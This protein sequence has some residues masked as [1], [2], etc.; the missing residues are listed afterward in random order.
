[1][2]FLSICLFRNQNKP[3]LN[4][5]K[6]G[7]KFDVLEKGVHKVTE[8]FF[9]D[10]LQCLSNLYNP[11]KVGR[12]VSRKL[13]M[14]LLVGLLAASQAEFNVPDGPIY[15]LNEADCTDG[16]GTNHCIQCINCFY[17]NYDGTAQ[18]GSVCFEGAGEA[19]PYFNE[20]C[21]NPTDESNSVYDG[22]NGDFLDLECGPNHVKVRTMCT[23]RVEVRTDN[24]HVDYRL[25]R[26][27]RAIR[28]DIVDNGLLGLPS[29]GG[30]YNL[31]ELRRAKAHCVGDNCNDLD[32]TPLEQT[33]ARDT[34]LQCKSCTYSKDLDGN[35]VDEDCVSNPTT[36]VTCD[37]SPGCM[38]DA[39]KECISF[40]GDNQNCYGNT[41][42]LRRGCSDYDEDTE[43]ST[44]QQLTQTETTVYQLREQGCLEINS[45]NSFSLNIDP[46][47]IGILPRVGNWDRPLTD[48]EQSMYC[49]VGGLDC[50]ECEV[51]QFAEISD[52]LKCLESGGQPNDQNKRE[53]YRRRYYDESRKEW[54]FNAC[55]TQIVN[56]I[57]DT[58]VASGEDFYALLRHVAQLSENEYSVEINKV[59]NTNKITEY[60]LSTND[61]CPRCYGSAGGDC[62]SGIDA[63]TE[64][65]STGV[66]RAVTNDENMFRSCL[67]SETFADIIKD[68]QIS[69]IVDTGS[70]YRYKQSFDWFVMTFSAAMEIDATSNTCRIGNSSQ[71]KN[72]IQSKHA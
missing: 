66:C 11:W 39:T 10:L 30:R 47:D 59:T 44:E 16:S 24:D 19:K 20:W 12:V 37:S 8:Q 72:T 13:E 60:E 34:G 25:Y 68:K 40:Y 27:A 28:A 23:V 21:V 70:T 2:T 32:V 64:P 57:A 55:Q 43:G 4:S 54:I 45:C 51:C 9:I 69:K 65:C 35:V 26:G 22:I 46:E 53:V 63:S 5:L 7:A 61:E 1:M 29:F 31:H 17:Q 14:K 71:Q 67:K 49:G 38:I 58:A 6:I 15:P 18:G 33:S 41:E 56:G 50:I 52:N 62:G 48:L 36:S 3:Q 42:I